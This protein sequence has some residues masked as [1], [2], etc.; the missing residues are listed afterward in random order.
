MEHCSYKK[1]ENNPVIKAEML[2]AGSSLVDFR[3]PKLWK[4]EKGFWSF[5]GYVTKHPYYII[6]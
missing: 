4:D 5:S 6:N 3:D 1:I 2:P